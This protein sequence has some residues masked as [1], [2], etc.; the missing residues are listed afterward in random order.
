MA[1]TRALFRTHVGRGLGRNYFVSSTTTGISTANEIVDT[2]RTEYEGHWAGSAI[3]VASAT[4]PRTALVRGN[5]TTG[6]L[7]LD[8][9]LGSAPA[10]GSVYELYKGFALAIFDE[11][12]D[13]AH[14]ECYPDLY[15]PVDDSTT[16]SET[17]AL[18]YTL[19]EAWRDIVQV[20]REVT[21]TNPVR[22]ERMLRG[23]EYDIRQGTAGLVLQLNYIPLS[24]TKL[25]VVGRSIPTL[26]TADSDTS[27]LP[28]QV[29]TPGALAYLYEN[30]SNPDE[31]AVGQKFAQEAQKQLALFERAKQRYAMPREGRTAITPRLEVLNTGSSVPGRF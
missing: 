8:T 14:G 5:A 19:P 22:Y 10:S 7:F 28:W 13:W 16:V 1:T 23:F 26:G 31:L 30:G 24:G 3:Y 6:R 12:I 21:G 2:A 17:T 15:G 4:A 25:H 11:A 29:I 27:L 9:D 20:R 18:T